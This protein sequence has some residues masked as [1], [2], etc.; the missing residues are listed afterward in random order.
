MQNVSTIKIHCINSYTLSRYH[1]KGLPSNFFHKNWVVRIF[2]LKPCISKR[3]FLT[4]WSHGMSFFLLSVPI[5]LHIYLFFF[6]IHNRETWIVI[7]V[8][9][10]CWAFFLLYIEQNVPAL[11]YVFASLNTFQGFAVFICFGLKNNEVLI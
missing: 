2:F 9:G 8:I 10:S 6:R 4:S 3:V 7:L 11:A 1:S 5:C